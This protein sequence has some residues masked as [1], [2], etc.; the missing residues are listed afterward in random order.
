MNNVKCI[1]TLLKESHNDIFSFQK[2][3]INLSYFAYMLEN[4]S[5]ATGMNREISAC[6]Q[7][8]VKKGRELLR[9]LI[10]IVQVQTA[11]QDSLTLGPRKRK[12]IRRGK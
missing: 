6:V 12:H 1:L 4:Y 11:L 7:K 9:Q 2:P 8:V 5:A 10:W 3:S